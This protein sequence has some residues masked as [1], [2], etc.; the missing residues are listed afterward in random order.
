MSLKNVY[1]RFLADH[2]Q[3]TSSLAAD[4]SLI[5]IP[6]TTKV[7]GRDAVLNYLTKQQKIVKTKAQDILGVVEGSDSLCLDVETTLEFDSGG[8]AYLPQLDN[9]FLADRVTSFP[10]VSCHTSTSLI[11]CMCEADFCA[12]HRFISSASTSRIR[13]RVFAFTG[14]RHRC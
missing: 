3:S 4:A 9:N 1:Q 10:T 13:F 11:S 14:N 7:E 8:G 5:Y 6:T 2:R 12:W